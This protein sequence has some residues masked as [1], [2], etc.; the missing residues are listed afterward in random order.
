VVSLAIF[1]ANLKVNWT[2]GLVL[3]AGSM[4]GAWLATRFASGK[5]AAWV[6]WFVIVVVATSAAQLLGVFAWLRGLLP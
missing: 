6:R 5:G 1:S 4:V 3:A 2:A